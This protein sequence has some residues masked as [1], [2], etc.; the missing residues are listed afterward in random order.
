MLLLEISRFKPKRKWK[1]LPKVNKTLLENTAKC[2]VSLLGSALDWQKNQVCIPLLFLK[3][4]SSH[5]KLQLDLKLLCFSQNL[6]AFSSIISVKLG[7]RNL[8]RLSRKHRSANSCIPELGSLSCRGPSRHPLPF[9]GVSP[10]TRGTQDFTN[11][12]HT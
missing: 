3:L 6:G 8:H 5:K 4:G 10:I 2:F 12:Y 1:L 11:W 9:Q 7:R